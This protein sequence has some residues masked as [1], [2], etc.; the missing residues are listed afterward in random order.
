MHTFAYNQK[1]PSEVRMIYEQLEE[2]MESVESETAQWRR[3]RILHQQPH[4]TWDNFFSGDEI[5]MYA[6]E[7]GFGLT[8]TCHRDRLPKGIPGKRQVLA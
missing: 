7:K 8:M 4:I 5:M 2:L 6:A 3:P 1:G